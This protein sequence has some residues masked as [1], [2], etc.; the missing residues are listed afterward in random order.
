AGRGG[1][2]TMKVL[3]VH[4]R[5]RPTAPSGEDAVVDQESAALTARG[6]E[7]ALFQRHSEEIAGWSPLRRGTLPVRLLWSE[8]SRRRITEL[9]GEFAP[10]VVHIHNIFPLVTPS[11][12]YACRDAS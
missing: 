12:L 10:D 7:V 2:T 5:Y 3:I 9:L 8:D 4:N 11:V 1:S 6:H